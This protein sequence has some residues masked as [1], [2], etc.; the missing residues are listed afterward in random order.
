MLFVFFIVV[1]P[2]IRFGK[3]SAHF[4]WF[5]FNEGGCLFGSSISGQHLANISWALATVS[6][7]DEIWFSALHKEMSTSAES[8]GKRFFFGVK[9][10][11][12]TVNI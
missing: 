11:R 12:S 4:H 5:F 3:S 1:D 6:H 9:R 2:K 10:G 7:E 8:T